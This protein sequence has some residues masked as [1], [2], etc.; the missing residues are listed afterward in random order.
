MSGKIRMKNLNNEFGY[1]QFTPSRI[2]LVNLAKALQEHTFSD[3]SSQRVFVLDTFSN[4]RYEHEICVALGNEPL[5]GCDSES[6]WKARQEP[7]NVSQALKVI[8]IDF[9]EQG[10]IHSEFL[11]VAWSMACE[12]LIAQA[13]EG[14]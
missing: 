7:C 1:A 13:I 8:Y 3:A 10:Y 5:G 14:V 4:L 11:L 12:I 2:T 9:V 6:Q